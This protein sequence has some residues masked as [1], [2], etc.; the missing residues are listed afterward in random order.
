EAPREDGARRHIALDEV[1][2]LGWRDAHLA[3]VGAI[4]G[5]TAR[6]GPALEFPTAALGVPDPVRRLDAA[7]GGTR[8]V[9]LEDDHAARGVRGRV[10][11]R[12]EHE[13]PVAVL[14]ELDREL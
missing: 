1:D 4:A 11:A 8:L 3:R 2:R 13:A 10:E 7:D 14:D 6:E 9:A 12:R 5:G